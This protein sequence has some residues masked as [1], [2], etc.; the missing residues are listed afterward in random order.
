MLMLNCSVLCRFAVS[1]SYLYETHS[2]VCVLH[3]QPDIQ[4]WSLA[5]S[6]EKDDMVS[7]SLLPVLYTEYGNVL[8]GL[9]WDYLILVIIWSFSSH[10]RRD[11]DESFMQTTWNPSLLRRGGSRRRKRRFVRSRNAS[12]SSSQKVASCAADPLVFKDRLASKQE[13]FKMFWWTQYSLADSG[14][15]PHRGAVRVHQSVVSFPKV[16]LKSVQEVVHPYKIL[17]CYSK[18]R[19]HP[20]VTAK[21]RPGPFPNAARTPSRLPS[22]SDPH[23]VLLLKIM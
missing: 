6:M 9:I 19:H 21:L 16:F 18:W 15:G 8:K 14:N 17:S 10:F 2:C 11:T 3:R 7:S 20:E 1:A 5:S 12:P 23:L 22:C 13:C 4:R